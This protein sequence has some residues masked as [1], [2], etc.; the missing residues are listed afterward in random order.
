MRTQG[1]APLA[2][3]LGRCTR[4]ALA[5]AVCLLLMAVLSGPASAT[6]AISSFGVTTTTTQAGGHPDLS[7]TFSL[8]EPGEPEAAQNVMVNLPEGVFGNP[9]AVPTCSVADFALFQCPYTS[10]VGTVMIRANYSGDPE[11]LLGTAPV[12]DLSVQVEGETARFAFVVPLLNLPI[13]VPIQVRTGSDYG[14]RM[15]VAGITQVMP[16]AEAKMTVWGFPAGDEYSNERFLPGGP[17]EPAGCPG[18]TNA[19]CASINGQ[20]PHTTHLFAQPLIDNPSTCTG[21]PLTVSLDVQTYQDPSHRT[22]AEDQFP[23]TTQCD[24]QTFKPVLNVGLTSNEADSPSGMDI[25]LQSSL[26]LSRAVSPSNIRS[27]TVTLPTGLSINPDAADGQLACSD[28][29]ANFGSEAPSECPASSKIGTFDI[30]TPALVGPLAGSLYFG[31][32]S[33]GNQYRVFMVA[34]GFG[35]NARIVASVSPDPKTGQLTVSVRDLPQVPF[36][37]FDLHLFASDRGLVAT[38]TQCRIYEVDSVF[39]PWNDR[40]AAQHSRPNLDVSSGPNGRGCPGEERPFSPHLVAGMSNPI[41]G[42]F[43]AF[44]LRL[45]REDGDQ[46]L[47]D[48]NFTMPPGLTGSLRGI[49]YCSEEAI[50]QAARQLGR[51]EQAYPSCRASSLI[52]TTNVAAGPGNH[53]FHA[54]GEMYLAGPFRGAPLSLVAITPAVAGPY[55]YGTQVVRVALHVDPLDAHVTAVSDTL[56]QI[57]GG[58]PL[59]MRTI[60]VNIDKPEFM[61]NPTNCSPFG[62]NSQGIGDQGTVADFSSYFHAVNCAKL[63]FQPKMTIRQLGSRSSTQRSKDPI[64]RFD[65]WTRKGNA[66]VKSLT[67]TLPKAFAID[68]RHLGNICSRAQLAAERCAGRQAIGHVET[69]TPLLDQPLSGPA[70]AV[71]GFG[72]L[73]HVVFI[74][75]GQVTLMPE[76][77]STSVNG[78]RLRTVVP[79]VPDAPIGHFRLDL[80]GGKQGYLVNTRSLCASNVVAEVRYSGQNG[81]TLEQSVRTKTACGKAETKRR[82]HPR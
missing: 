42:A 57:I 32:P 59:R 46:Y 45:D 80:L 6:E 22:H 73:P 52:G 43:S 58:V 82:R 77:E 26:F 74:L 39:T 56:P 37:G 4:A 18:K 66:N 62:I 30:R 67:V 21:E 10:Q 78:G 15:T 47:G 64:L 54:V 71:S 69:D 61:I 49:D 38:P 2:T 60:Q 13:S 19:M 27:A 3:S 8:A 51:A 16:L 1:N 41:A 72:K 25:T 31:E 68:Q 23:A 5:S 20:A 29:K 79:V 24:Q 33:P 70:Y 55:D 34:S 63:N 81:R 48:L 35:I 7:A 36:E 17:G 14:L 44:S 50:Q 65:L 76:A 75:D 9:N 28:A 12:Y 53:P 40:L 11:F